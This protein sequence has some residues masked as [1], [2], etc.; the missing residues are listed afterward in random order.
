MIVALWKDEHAL[1]PNGRARLKLGGTKGLNG[2]VPENGRCT[3]RARYN[4]SAT[5][6]Q[7]RVANALGLLFVATIVVLRRLVLGL[8]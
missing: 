6:L 8:Y 5:G 1:A 3:I 2:W 4:E 7:D